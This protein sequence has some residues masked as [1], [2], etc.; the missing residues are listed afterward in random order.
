M[1]LIFLDF[2]GVLNDPATW[3]KFMFTSTGGLKG[4]AAI[5]IDK[6]ERVNQIIAAT[7]AFVVISSMWR[8]DRTVNELKQLLESRGFKGT[9]FGATPCNHDTWRCNEISEYLDGVSHVDAY[10]ILDDDPR[11]NI[12][13]HFVNTDSTVGLTDADVQKAI[14]IL[15]EKHD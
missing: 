1:K 6:V 2:D 10:V 13:D 11:A 14:E 7:G 12:L 5:D 9:L 4:A 3:G 15:N 8:I